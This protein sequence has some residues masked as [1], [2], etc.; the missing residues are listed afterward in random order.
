MEQTTDEMVERLRDPRGQEELF[1]ADLDGEEAKRTFSTWKRRAVLV[2]V[3]LLGVAASIS[4]WLWLEHREVEHLQVQLRFDAQGYIDVFERRLQERVDSVSALMMIYERSIDDDLQRYEF[5]LYVETYL[6]QQ[7]DVSALIYSPAIEGDRREHHRADGREVWGAQ[8][9]LLARGDDGQFERSPRRDRHLPVYYSV[10]TTEMFPPGFDWSSHDTVADHLDEIIDAGDV[11]AIGPLEDVDGS[12]VY[13]IFGPVYEPGP[14]FRGLMAAVF[15]LAQVVDEVR[16][17]RLPVPIDFVLV[18]GADGELY[19]WSGDEE[20]GAP[21]GVE[22]EPGER[23]VE[24]QFSKPLDIPGQQWRVEARATD[25]YMDS[26]RS[27]TP[28]LFL[29][30]GL[31]VTAISVF[32]MQMMFGR[33]ERIEEVVDERTASLRDHRKRL[34]KVAVEMARARQEAVEANQA[35]STFLANMSHEI[36]T[37]MNGVIG[38]AELLEETDLD[39]QQREYLTLL[40]RSAR[41]LLSLLNDIL[42]FSKIEAGEL[43]L[44]VREFS[45]GD[46]VAETL[47]VMARRADQKDLAL[48]YE[49]PR[50]LPYTVVGDPGRL[51]QILINLIGNAVKFTEQGEISV[52]VRMR[53]EIDDEVVLHFEVCDTGIGIGPSQQERIFEAFQQ[54]DGSVRRVYEGTGLGLAIASQLVRLMGGKIWLDSEQG[55]GSTFHFTV[56][57]KRGQRQ[58]IGDDS[59]AARLAGLKVLIVEDRPADESLLNELLTAWKLE[60]VT[61]RDPDRLEDVVEA[62][63]RQGEPIELCVVDVDVE[64]S[65]D[66]RLYDQLIADSRFEHLPVIAVSYAENAPAPSQRHGGK[67]T[68]LSKPVKPSDL[69]EAIVDLVGASRLHSSAPSEAESDDRQGACV[70]LVEDSRINQKVTAGLLE[71]RG[72]RVEIADDGVAGVHRYREDPEHFDLVLMDVQMPRMDGFEATRKIR[73]IDR[74]ID[75][76]VPIVALTAH[77]MK[78]DRERMLEAGMDD[79]MAKPVQPDDLYRLMERWTGHRSAPRAAGGD[80]GDAS[81]ADAPPTE[82]DDMPQPEI[83]DR[84]RAL[85]QVGGD[86]ELLAELAHRFFGEADDWIDTLGRALDGGEP[87]QV[88]STAHTLKGAADTIGSVEV[89]QLARRLEEAGRQQQL[90][91]GEELL[92]QLP[93][94]LERLQQAIDN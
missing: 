46:L 58:R 66:D 60:P 41:G 45:P 61:L 3:S 37:P 28:T 13:G 40:E 36:R 67:T 49:V 64:L 34:Q 27:P 92:A 74:Q 75:H 24:R 80:G 16:A 91:R 63:K 35:K 85:E 6:E 1:S 21:H 79:Y 31:F 8:Y 59:P 33:A 17:R 53:D 72:H 88:E 48:T 51:R 84:E 70:L 89:T 32:L 38:M 93:D 78:G 42:D 73:Q 10:P 50:N 19:S 2:L 20:P 83:F 18:D 11:I 65:L 87:D 43:E 39:A 69:L 22:H 94:A 77:A 44:D 86:P 47:Q 57:L 62:A 54:V 82:D 12:P 68:W 71:R 9:Q 5:E 25:E 55:A 81:N 90:Q 15:H 26:H 76:K 23:S 7:I 56:R 52:S 30:F 29:S 4:G 14:E